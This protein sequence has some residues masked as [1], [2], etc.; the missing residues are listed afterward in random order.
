MV[1]MEIHDR[2]GFE[3]RWK[4][5]RVLLDDETPLVR[6]ALVDRLKDNAEEGI[7][8]LREMA[9]DEDLFLA[10]HAQDLIKSLGWVDGVRDFIDFIRSQR[11]ELETGWFL[12]D[13][14]VYPSF[15]PSS[16]TLFLDKLA[17]RC[18]ELFT[19][20]M[21]PLETCSVMNRVLFHEY[22]FRGAGKDFENPQNS[23]L[24]RVL[25]RKKGLPITLSVIYILIAR[26]LG[27]DLEPIGLPGRFM[28]GCFSEERPFYV[29][30]WSGG[31][32]YEV[33]QIEE[34]LGD[35]SIEDSGSALLPVTV[36]DT[37]V[38]G[39]RN[40]IHHYLKA[41]DPEK[42]RVFTSFVCEFERIQRIAASA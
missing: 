16:A 39:C 10:K 23:F 35:Y 38:R 28:V 12:L 20:P 17:D 9:D 33:D 5:C 25:E 4:P 15:E 2:E 14:T 3:R 40:L 34:F 41:E 19:S 26:R 13:R 21:L 8:F 11:Y 24:H 27:F 31:R 30:P 22:G 7:V 29:D 32:V 36:A 18:R 42:S 1:S 37:L 6:Q